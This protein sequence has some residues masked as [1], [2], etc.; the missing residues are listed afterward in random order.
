MARSIELQRFYGRKAWQD[1]RMVKILQSHGRCERCGADYSNNLPLLIAHHI[2][3]LTDETLKDPE[4]SLN[5]ENVEILCPRCHALQ[6]PERGF[7]KKRKQVF[8]VYG[9]PLSGK[10]TYVRQNMESGDLVIDLDVIYSSL[11]LLPMYD[12]PK[13]LSRVV[14]AVRD[15]LYD[16]IRIRNG[17]WPAAWIVAGLPRKDERERLAARMGADCILIEASKEECLERL[18]NNPGGRS[19]EW[20]GHIERWFADY[21]P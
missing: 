15:C 4:I 3:P 12:R 5:P 6:H 17:D 13:G 16:Q 7:I 20:A 14:F 21:I 1:L 19:E 11:S 9:P 8:I 10:S 2:R 18:R